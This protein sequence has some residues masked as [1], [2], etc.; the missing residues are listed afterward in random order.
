M[1]PLVLLLCTIL[2]GCITPEQMAARQAWEAEQQELRNRAYTEGL[3][4]QCTAVGYQDGTEGFRNCLLTLHSQA[5]Q[6]AAQMRG[7]LLQN[8]IQQQQQQ[9]QR[10]TYTNCQ[11]DYF[12]NVSCISR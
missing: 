3:R 7:I 5:Q 8:A 2:A 6:N 11:R 10:P 12:G 9:Q 4:R 1:K